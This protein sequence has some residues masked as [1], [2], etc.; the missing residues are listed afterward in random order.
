MLVTEVKERHRER[1]RGLQ[2]L[3]AK[4][5]QKSLSSNVSELYLHNWTESRGA[6]I[7]IISVKARLTGWGGQHNKNIKKELLTVVVKNGCFNASVTVIRFSGSTT[8]HLRIKSFGSSANVYNTGYKTSVHS[9]LSHT[10]KPDMSAHSGE[11]KLY[12]PSI[13]LRNM[14][15]CLRC[16]NGGQPTSSVNI[17]T[18][19]AQ[20]ST[21]RE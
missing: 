15:I 18:P 16:Q 21:S 14:T 9:T 5:L 3:D 7:I 1:E 19:H 13:I 8:K 12:F 6:L 4:F 20:M 17:M 2:N 10:H 11:V